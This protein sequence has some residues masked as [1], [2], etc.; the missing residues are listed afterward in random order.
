MKMEENLQSN[1]IERLTKI[2]NH[3]EEKL[4]SM[5]TVHE[6]LFQL[7]TLVSNTQENIIQNLNYVQMLLNQQKENSTSSEDSLSTNDNPQI[8]DQLT[9]NIKSSKSVSF[10][11]D[12]DLH[13]EQ[14]KFLRTFEKFPKEKSLNSQFDEKINLLYSLRNC[15]IRSSNN[16]NQSCINH[17]ISSRK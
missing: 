16:T 6:N 8:S 13:P 7:M 10:S 17:R 2:F 11:L 4:I 9:T 1:L 15:F 14:R 5:K 12:Q 3:L